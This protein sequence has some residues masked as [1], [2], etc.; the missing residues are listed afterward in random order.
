[1][2]ARQR[3]L[4]RGQYGLADTPGGATTCLRP[5]KRWIRIGMDTVTGPST[6]RSR[7][8]SPVNATRRARLLPERKALQARVLAKWRSK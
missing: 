3:D 1:M 7:N 8:G 2:A 6:A 5:L 4:Q